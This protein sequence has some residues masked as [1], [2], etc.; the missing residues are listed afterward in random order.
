MAVDILEIYN[1]FGA[2]VKVT[3]DKTAQ[4]KEMLEGLDDP[5]DAACC[6]RAFLNHY[7]D[8]SLLHFCFDRLVAM[9]PEAMGP[10]YHRWRSELSV[11]AEA[12]A[13]NRRAFGQWEN[14]FYQKMMEHHPVVARNLWPKGLP[15]L[16]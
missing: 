10:R 14:V 5:V 15:S 12:L 8:E 3:P 16:A 13:R 4:I 1:L 7:P 9:R 2:R 11:A 6:I